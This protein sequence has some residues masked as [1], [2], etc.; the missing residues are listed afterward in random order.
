MLKNLN[1]NISSQAFFASNQKLEV[2]SKVSKTKLIPI[3]LKAPVKFT[4]FLATVPEKTRNLP[5]ESK[6]PSATLSKY[7]ASKKVDPERPEP[8]A[9]F[10]QK[11]LDFSGGQN[12]PAYAAALQAYIEDRIAISYVEKAFEKSLQAD[13]NFFQNID[14]RVSKNL[15]QSERTLAV[16]ENLFQ[17]LENFDSI[18]S[19]GQHESS[20][21]L[22]ARDLTENYGPAE[23]LL[24][25]N[26]IFKDP[27]GNVKIGYGNSDVN[28]FRIFLKSESAIMAMNTAVL[29]SYLERGCSLNLVNA[30][31]EMSPDA[32][33][34]QLPNAA[35]KNS[36]RHISLKKL[37]EEISKSGTPFESKNKPKGAQKLGYY[38]VTAGSK[39]YKA[40]AKEPKYRAAMVLST[41][42]ANEL[43]L[44]AGIGRLT[45]TPLGESFG[46]DSPNFA[47]NFCGVEPGQITEEVTSPNSLADYFLVSRN[48][49]P[50]A[51]NN[52]VNVL[53]FEGIG[54]QNKAA[55][56]NVDTATQAFGKS[57][58]R[59]PT[60]NSM[61]AFDSALTNSQSRS[62]SAI[63]LYSKLHG[64]DQELT[65]LTPRGL[66]TRIAEEVQ[67]SLSNAS[68]GINSFD[69]NVVAELALFSYLGK[70]SFSSALISGQESLRSLL[71]TQVCRIAFSGLQKKSENLVAGEP[72]SPSAAKKTRVTVQKN[73]GASDT[74]VVSTQ[75][76]SPPESG[77]QAEIE[78]FDLT[79]IRFSA[80]DQKNFVEPSDEFFAQIFAASLAGIEPASNS[81]D[82]EIGFNLF[83]LLQNSEQDS[84]SIINR[85]AKIFIEAHEEAEAFAG[86][87]G[88]Q[89]GFLRPNR[90]TRASQIDGS[91]LVG[92]IF[93]A[94][95]ALSSVFFNAR[96][97]AIDGKSTFDTIYL[98]YVGNPNN[99]LTEAI[100]NAYTEMVVKVSGRFGQD[101]PNDLSARAL[102][103][104]VDASK[105]NTFEN[106]YG[107]NGLI[108]ALDNEKKSKPIT[109]NSI[110]DSNL[111]FTACQEIFEE[112]A[113]ERD[114]PYSSILA[115]VAK[116]QFVKAQTA[117]FVDL[118][119]QLAGTKEKDPVAADYANFA[120]TIIGKKFV[121]S[122][123][124]RSLQI[125][126][127][128]MKSIA[129]KSEAASRRIPRITLAEVA[130][131]KVLCEDLASKSGE[132]LVFL[133]VGMPAEFIEN[134]ILPEFNEVEGFDSDPS[135]MTMD[136]RVTA[137]SG[138]SGNQISSISRRYSPDNLIDQTSFFVFSDIDPTNIS[139]IVN[140]VL[141][142]NGQT[143]NEFVN[144]FANSD[145]ASEILK[146]E[147]FSYLI[148][149]VFSVTTPNDLFADVMQPGDG[150]KR[151]SGSSV[152]AQTL[153]SNLG[154][155]PSVVSGVFVTEEGITKFDPSALLS[156]TSQASIVG[157]TSQTVTMSPIDFS[158][159]DL[160]A[161]AF[162][163]LAFNT[164][165]IVETIF[166]ETVYEKVICI[167]F[168][169]NEFPDFNIA[170]SAKLVN[171]KPVSSKNTYAAGFSL[172]DKVPA[173]IKMNTYE[174]NVLPA[175][176]LVK[177]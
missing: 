112:L 2:T 117:E 56:L 146:N 95:C 120:Q 40:L 17:Q 127:S 57:A 28:A 75:D 176:S 172:A 41:L 9:I 19:R 48:G 5:V 49:N 170:N 76:E 144:S 138:I 8:I 68:L 103:L 119:L 27:R 104:L 93:H 62:Q 163:S 153:V 123:T 136:C 77:G 4:K 98:N 154:M 143:G 89:N 150:Y 70:T 96:L 82:A 164:E 38:A 65:L 22:F 37:G 99:S 140:N 86:A 1:I 21:E 160:L 34:I 147:I 122:A 116:Q 151:D 90:F 79:K 91:T 72:K 3:V 24:V 32:F 78:S 158:E 165:Q 156:K 139:D 83:Q 168:S 51:Q 7:I 43:C 124:T 113:E 39:L 105:S 71:F 125:A 94:A 87:D 155:D 174:V 173:S 135:L 66:F 97:L 126:R 45:G 80:D 132:S 159:A 166:S 33:G 133:N 61:P 35:A 47:K 53:L 130:C 134:T 111:S 14:N 161:D 109:P 84:N 16:M 26:P 108:P 12:S 36:K 54:R 6:T 157:P 100:K 148:R 129:R 149:K 107:E 67:K 177:K 69:Q 59:Y 115:H 50:R 169:S 30:S 52:A 162:S 101:T 131:Y 121:E 46:I 18:L 81:T 55:A 15:Q 31:A 23:P 114:V 145:I 25:Q 73:G 74:F 175:D 10:S 88:G 92:M 128:K 102:K 42:V 60:N 171:G 44:S 20:I 137:Y 110:S 167:P 118:S 141:L 152:L 85:I 29:Q 64:R 142:T 58:V 11:T 106:V 13:E 63:E